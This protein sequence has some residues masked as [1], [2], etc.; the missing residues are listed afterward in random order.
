MFKIVT[1]FNA[2]KANEERWSLLK[3]AVGGII[4]K[5]ASD[6]GSVKLLISGNISFQMITYY[7]VLAILTMALG[8]FYIEDNQDADESFTKKDVFNA[9]HKELDFLTFLAEQLTLDLKND[10][11]NQLVAQAQVEAKSELED[12]KE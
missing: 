7:E 11:K 6:V 8:S 5:M 9:T 3:D 10:W 4:G 1:D 2:L 12:E